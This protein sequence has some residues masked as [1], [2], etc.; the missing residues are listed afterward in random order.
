[1]SPRLSPSSPFFF[2]SIRNHYCDRLRFFYPFW[3]ILKKLVDEVWLQRPYLSVVDFHHHFAYFIVILW[4]WAQEYPRYHYH[5]FPS[6]FVG[7]RALVFLPT[8]RVSNV[9]KI[10]RLF[11]TK[12]GARGAGMEWNVK[13]QH[14]SALRL[15]HGLSRYRSRLF[16]MNP[17]YLNLLRRGCFFIPQAP[18]PSSSE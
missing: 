1:M 17:C 12:N 5:M 16:P 6:K 7:K 2:G 3:S 8:P 14:W 15:H 10:Q 9:C 11:V 13:L 4:K 18:L